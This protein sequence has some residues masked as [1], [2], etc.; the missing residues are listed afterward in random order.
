MVLYWFIEISEKYTALWR[1]GSMWLAHWEGQMTMLG[2]QTA[3]ERGVSKVVLT[4]CGRG[5]R[6]VEQLLSALLE[7]IF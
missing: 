7:K 4:A 2:G 3:L 5:V 1:R 6:I